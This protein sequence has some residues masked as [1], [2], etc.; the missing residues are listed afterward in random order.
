MRR[1]SHLL[2][3]MVLATSI[4]NFSAVA[5]ADDL[6]IKILEVPMSKVNTQGLTIGS[7]GKVDLSFYEP[8]SVEFTGSAALKYS[9]CDQL[10]DGLKGLETTWIAGGITNKRSI[11]RSNVL[12]TIGLTKTGIQ[13]ALSRRVR[14]SWG[15]DYTFAPSEQSIPMTVSISLAGE[16][17]AEKIGILRNPNYSPPAPSITG[18]SSGDTVNGFLKF[19]LEG[20]LPEINPKALPL[21]GLCPPGE[22]LGPE[23]GWGYL[24]ANG[25]AIVVANPNSYEKTT[26]LIVRWDIPNETGNEV[27]IESKVT[28]IN[29]AA[30]TTPIPWEVMSR[31]SQI[32]IDLE[33]NCG[34]SALKPGAE[35]NCQVN[36]QLIYSRPNYGVFQAKLNATINF[37]VVIKSDNCEE[38]S[39]S[40]TFLSNRESVYRL[41]I[42]KE[43]T[44]MIKFKFLPASSSWRLSTENL[45][46]GAEPGV[47]LLGANPASFGY[48]GGTGANCHNYTTRDARPVAKVPTGKVDKSSNAYKK[49]LAVGKNFGK[50]SRAEDTARS[51][52]T[53]A[54]QSGIIRSNGIPK[55]L[56]TQT[57]LIQS[58]LKTPSGF[59]GC[60]DGFGR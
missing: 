42:P 57:T 5:H 15:T 54:L 24:D 29:V 59:Q 58:Y 7:N 38:Q 18:V 51:Q 10:V 16:K 49:M 14:S 11:E 27:G 40:A 47:V 2:A 52:C 50:V 44:S 21:I 3:F 19:K 9:S 41:K 43:T 17:L 48:S 37:R 31:L 28:G 60:L 13:C 30:N 34:S 12:Y 6:S 4:I 20:N 32:K 53:S 45:Y 26:S 22:N 23:C 1:V 8:Y 25:N 55:Y 35:L 46:P 39:S 56:G 33:L 36:P